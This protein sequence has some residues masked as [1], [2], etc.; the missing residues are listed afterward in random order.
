MLRRFFGGEFVGGR[1]AT[2][3]LVLRL[4]FGLGLMAHGW[5]KIQN[6]FAWMGDA[7]VPG[8]LQFLAA[9]SEF[10]GGLSLIGGLFVRLSTL[11]IMATMLFAAVVAHS[12]DP[13]VASGPGGSKEPAL[14]YFAVALCLFLTGAGTLSLDYLLFGRKNAVVAT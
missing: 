8:V 14:S 11:G 13:F 10:F 1:G 4:M 2:G 7:P 3:L 5:G 6:P 12:N 9:F